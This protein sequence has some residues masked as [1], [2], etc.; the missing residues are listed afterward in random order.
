[1]RPGAGRAV[2]PW[3]R[4]SRAPP[5]SRARSSRPRR[6]ASH[7]CPPAEPTRDARV[8]RSSSVLRASC[9]S[10]PAPA[11]AGLLARRRRLGAPARPPTPTP[12]QGGLLRRRWPAPGPRREV[13][14]QGPACPRWPTF[15]KKG[16]KATGSG[17]LTQ[18]PPN[19]GAGWY[20]LATGA[21]PGV[22]GS[23]NNTFHI[24]GSTVRELD[25]RRSTPASSRRRSIAQAAERAGLK[26]AQVEWAGG[27]QR[28]TIRARRSTSGASSP[29]AA[30]RR[31]TSA[32]RRLFDARRSSRSFGL[33]F[34]HPA[35]YAGNAPVP[36]GGARPPRPAGPTCPASFSPAEEMRLR[37]LDCRR[38]TS[39]ASTPTSTTAPT[40][41]PT[42]YDRVLFSTDQGR[43]A[44]AS[45]TSREGEWAD[46]KVKIV[47]GAPAPARPPA[48][49]S[50]SRS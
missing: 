12:A 27:S 46:V 44:R 20:T 47:G 4:A 24:N 18:A 48:S 40:T 30:S 8:P 43:R 5:R 42:N 32:R 16:A 39:T 21:W 3:R 38:P 23:T 19:T 49:S 35:G 1:M 10:S 9:P 41:A 17:L 45:A 15:L 13:R 2:R 6:P 50:R 14:G 25:R 28:R 7:P 22:H 33:Q 34:D 26:V 31:T 36:G 29:A 37:V 11:A